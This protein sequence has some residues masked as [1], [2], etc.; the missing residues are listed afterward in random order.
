MRGKQGAGSHTLH[1][2]ETDPLLAL[3]VL[4]GAKMLLLA[5]TGEKAQR[6]LNERT[7]ILFIYVREQM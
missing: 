4:I 2:T 6:G 7:I 1:E 5:T 3:L